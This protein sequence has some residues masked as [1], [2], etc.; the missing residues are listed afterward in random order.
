[1]FRNVDTENSDAGESPNRKNTT[2]KIPPALLRVYLTV[3]GLAHKQRTTFHVVTLRALVF[4]IATQLKRRL[5]YRH[6][7]SRNS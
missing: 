6:V 4:P 5:I 3:N 7:K 1:M 2:T